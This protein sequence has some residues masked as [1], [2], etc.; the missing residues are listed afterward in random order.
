MKKT[1][2]LKQYTKK[3]F[4]EGAQG[5]IKPQTRAWQNCYKCKSDKGKGPQEAWDE[6]LKEYQEFSSSD[7]SLKYSSSEQS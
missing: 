2:N 6:C 3:A 4:Y 7:W 1:F 5:Y